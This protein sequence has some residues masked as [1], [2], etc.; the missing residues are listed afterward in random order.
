MTIDQLTHLERK[1][2]DVVESISASLECEPVDASGE[3][4]D[5]R[6][7]DVE[8]LAASVQ[9]LAVSVARIRERRT[10]NVA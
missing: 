6:A 8:Y 2:L 1:L 5:R 4:I 10:T 9:D 7:S 3:Y